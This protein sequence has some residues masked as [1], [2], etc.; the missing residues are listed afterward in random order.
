MV[1]FTAVRDNNVCR[2]SAVYDCLARGAE[3]V[4]KAEVVFGFER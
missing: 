3:G 2:E 1:V 4:R